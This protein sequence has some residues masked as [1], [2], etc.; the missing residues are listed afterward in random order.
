MH[1]FVEFRGAPKWERERGGGGGPEIMALRESAPEG[2]RHVSSMTEPFPGS[3][4]GFPSQ[5]PLR[6]F[7][8]WSDLQD[9]FCQCQGLQP[10][11]GLGYALDI[12]LWKA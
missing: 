7:D 10:K 6:L 12:G 3:T 5:I 9:V 2:H 8:L 11:T 4:R 1:R